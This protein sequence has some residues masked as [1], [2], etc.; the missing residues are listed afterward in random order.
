MDPKTSN[1]EDDSLKNLDAEEA[2]L[3]Q[4][5]MTI[6]PVRPEDATIKD[7]TTEGDQAAPPA[8]DTA[9]QTSD[10]A[11]KAAADKKAAD[12]K[13]AKEKASKESADK[14]PADEKAAADKKAAD[15]KAAADKKAAEEEKNLT[16][17][18]KERRRLDTSWKKL[19]EE[20]AATRKEREELAAERKKLE[21]ERTTAAA[22]AAKPKE[23]PTHNGFTAD[24]YEAAAADFRKDGKTE[25]AAIAEKRAKELRD[26]EAEQA[27]TAGG[28]A[29][30][31]E[32]ITLPTGARI[33]ADEKKKME[34]EWQANLKK[35][36]DENPDLTKD[37]TPLRAE[38]SA[39]LKSH[40]ILHSHG[41]G[42]HYA[43]EVAKLK[44]AAAEVPT[45]KT[46]ITELETE[47]KRLTELTSLNP[48]GGG[49]EGRRDKPK[50]ED[51]PIDQA[52]TALREEAMAA[53]ARGG[54]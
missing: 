42:I 39:L 32:F 7:D 14:K 37:G 8:D 13:A 31:G 52:E 18:Q 22:A 36:G 3:R 11:N 30:S 35:L 10:A 47:N 29:A 26:K 54:Q 4:E 15:E 6:D 19:D 1:T 2:A 43:V 44:L 38:V 50:T 12:E 20:K 34:G 46:R 23:K 33:T 27:K 16:P 45:L 17:Y 9:K 21:E 53:D 41:S 49:G 24:D 48:S 40:P 25:E 51:M 5:A 28:A